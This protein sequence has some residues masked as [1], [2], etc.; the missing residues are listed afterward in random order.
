[1]SV[2]SICRMERM[3]MLVIRA[4]EIILVLP[5][6][7]TP[8]P[9]LINF[10]KLLS[11]AYVLFTA[12]FPT[13]NHAMQ[14]FLFLLTCRSPPKA[15]SLFRLSMILGAHMALKELQNTIHPKV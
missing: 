12:N 1:M 10:L 7:I 2:T 6:L 13:P 9:H 11:D 4:L 3:A 15:H 5:T 8:S 14:V